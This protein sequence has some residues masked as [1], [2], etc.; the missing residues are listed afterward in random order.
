MD[1]GLLDLSNGDYCALPIDK[2]RSMCYFCG[3]DATFVRGEEGEFFSSLLSSSA[4]NRV[5]LLL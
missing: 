1:A 2:V 4:N 3:S 5:S